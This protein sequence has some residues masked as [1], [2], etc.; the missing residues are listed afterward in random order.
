[1]P[2]LAHL[3]RLPP[4]DAALLALRAQHVDDLHGAAIAEE[5]AQRLLVPGDAMAFHERDEIPR[6]VAL[7]R[8]A[9]ERGIGREVIR[10]RCVEVGEVATAAAGNSDLLADLLVVIDEQDPAA[11]L[12]RRGGA[13]H[14]RGPGADDGDVERGACSFRRGSYLALSGA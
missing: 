8:R 4:F 12:P 5:L 11:P 3:A 10:M 1:M 13:H 2:Q 9:A 6:R 14:A 7:E